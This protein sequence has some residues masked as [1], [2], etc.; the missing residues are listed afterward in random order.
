MPASHKTV[1][2]RDTNLEKLYAQ[3]SAVT[4]PAKGAA[5]KSTSPA[6]VGVPVLSPAEAKF[7][8][9]DLARVAISALLTLLIILAVYATSGSAYW[10]NFITW[11]AELTHF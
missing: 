10:T 5:E 4:E 3:Y 8:R 2:R 6:V 7:V 9:R 11:L 1:K